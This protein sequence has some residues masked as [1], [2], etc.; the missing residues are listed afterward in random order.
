VYEQFRRDGVVVTKYIEP[1][2]GMLHVYQLYKSLGKG[3]G[4]ASRA[5]AG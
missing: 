3:G 1:L 5:S 2:E 4:S